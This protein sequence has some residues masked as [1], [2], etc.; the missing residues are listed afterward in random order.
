MRRLVPVYFV[1]VSNVD[2]LDYLKALVYKEDIDL[3][4]AM[5]ATLEPIDIDVPQEYLMEDEVKQPSPE[6]DGSEPAEEV[7]AEE[8]VEETANPDLGDGAPKTLQWHKTQLSAL[9]GSK[10]I[11]NYVSE[12]IGRDAEPDIDRRKG[13]AAIRLRAVKLI[14]EFMDNAD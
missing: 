4:I 6:A 5:G 11:V 14:K 9:K 8:V 2:G 10:Q 7:T 13:L 1:G 3:F 12:V